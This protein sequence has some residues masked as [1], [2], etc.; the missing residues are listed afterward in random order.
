MSVLEKRGKGKSEREE[1][2][3][4][5]A[6]GSMRLVATAGQLKDEYL[7]RLPMRPSQAAWICAM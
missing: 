3:G 7:A 1:N 4:S 2:L 6:K 5:K